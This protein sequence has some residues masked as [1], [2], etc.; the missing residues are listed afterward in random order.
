MSRA[1]GLVHEPVPHWTAYM[2]ALSTPMVAVL[3]IYIAFRQWKT[4]HEKLKLDLFEKRLAIYDQVTIA[5]SRVLREGVVTTQ[6]EADIFAGSTQS[7]WLL[8]AELADYL[9][10]DVLKL[11]MDL[12]WRERRIGQISNDDENEKNADRVL[13]M[14][15][16]LKREYL[17]IDDKFT[18]FLRIER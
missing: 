13:E 10:E 8:N 7:R 6:D 17:A 5:L 15:E 12:K 2:A 11:L 18:P 14:R 16:R 9:K 1:L 4:A 3:G